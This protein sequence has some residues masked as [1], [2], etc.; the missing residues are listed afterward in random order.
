MSEPETTPRLPS[1]KLR[2][3]RM[4]AKR[5]HP[6][7]EPRMGW[8]DKGRAGA[9]VVRDGWVRAVPGTADKWS[10]PVIVLTEAGQAVL[11]AAM[12]G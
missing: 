3:L 1:N 5:D 7:G 4:V 8:L 11:T 2:M 6:G 10:G 12:E 9:D